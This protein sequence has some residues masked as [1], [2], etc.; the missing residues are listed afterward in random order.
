MPELSCPDHEAKI[1]VLEVEVTHLQTDSV[2]TR[3]WLSSIDRKV[4]DIKSRLDKQNGAIPH[5]QSDISE[6]TDLMKDMSTKQQDSR[7]ANQ[8][9]KLKTGMMWSGLGFVIASII[10][11]IIK[12]VAG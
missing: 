5:M 11:L 10:G 3:Q 12:V 9:F 2:N 1:A 6:L 7:V 4:D 8:E